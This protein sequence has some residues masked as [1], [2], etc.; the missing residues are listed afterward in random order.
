MLKRGAQPPP[1]SGLPSRARAR[2]KIPETLPSPPP[3]VKQLAPTGPALS[4]PP[5]CRY[6]VTTRRAHAVRGGH[7]APVSPQA[8]GSLL[9]AA[10]DLRHLALPRA[11]ARS[12][13]GRSPRSANVGQ[14][15]RNSGLARG[16][17]PSP[18]SAPRS[19]PRISPIV[20]AGARR[21][22]AAAVPTSGSPPALAPACPLPRL[23]LLH[24]LPAG[25]IGRRRA[26]S[27][28]R[29]QVEYIE[30]HDAHRRS[31]EKHRGWPSFQ[32]SVLFYSVYRGAK[33]NNRF[34][35]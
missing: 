35:F 15:A 20:V 8:G 31:A 6:V 23:A 28:Y 18:R 5:A 14:V 1:A 33:L 30:H 2:A 19:S 22:F 26:R 29:R 25:L 7:P 12:S 27:G 16:S 21:P 32:P 9:F 10:P 3:W 13:G 11:H 17:C 4:L 24:E 34:R